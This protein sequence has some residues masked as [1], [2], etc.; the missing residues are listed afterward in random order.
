MENRYEA[1][2]NK[3][4]HDEGIEAK[5]AFGNGF[6]AG[7][8]AAGS[9]FLSALMIIRPY[10]KSQERLPTPTGTDEKE[11]VQSCRKLMKSFSGGDWEQDVDESGSFTFPV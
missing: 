9:T 6:F 2:E 1:E 4:E 3:H 7:L 5:F 10:D 11:T 8:V